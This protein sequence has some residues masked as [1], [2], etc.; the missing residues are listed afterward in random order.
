MAHELREPHDKQSMKTYKTQN[1]TAMRTLVSRVLPT[2]QWRHHGI[3]ALQAYV[4][5]TVRIH[6]WHDTLVLPGMRESGAI[7]DHRFDLESTVL[8][9][10]LTN[11]EYSEDL[12]HG[13]P[14]GEFDMYE[15]LKSKDRIAELRKVA[16]RRFISVRE[17]E[18]TE[19]CTY[20]YPK[21]R[22]HESIHRGTT[23]TLVTKSNQED[24]PPRIL[25]P[26]GTKPVNAL[27]TQFDSSKTDGVIQEAA[28][29]L[30]D[31]A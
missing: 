25:A 29:L 19:G 15:V 24:F 30:R 6:V 11:R 21:R 22:F 26:A 1:L 16:T 2:L 4:S 10:A 27:Q 23:V 31:S 20:T 3:G 14:L 18:L 17:T 13:I 9:G 5:E 7:H 12:S 8:V 28:T